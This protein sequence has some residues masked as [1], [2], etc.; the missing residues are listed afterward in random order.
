MTKLYLITNSYEE[1]D[2]YINYEMTVPNNPPGSDKVFLK[3]PSY[4][5]SDDEKNM[6]KPI[7]IYFKYCGGVGTRYQ[8]N[9]NTSFQNSKSNIDDTTYFY[10]NNL[11][12]NSDKI[13]NN[14]IS[15]KGIIKK[16]K[17]NKDEKYPKLYLYLIINEH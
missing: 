16:G 4:T 7:T 11:I 8:Y 2:N 15:F 5:F 14:N 3:I 17:I 1:L 12:G 13:F 10:S 9:I 6:D